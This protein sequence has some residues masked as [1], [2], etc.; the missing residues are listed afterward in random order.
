MLAMDTE[1]PSV[2]RI[3]LDAGADAR[4]KDSDGKTALMLAARHGNLS[5][6]QTLIDAGADLNATDDDGWTALMFVDEAEVAR[7]LLN[8]GADFTIKNKDG[9]TALGMARKYEKT[10]VV[11]LL[12]SRGAPQ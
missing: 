2:V 6:V 5:T 10:E 7:V 9:E 3:L 8:A 1:A 4:A 12:E 11:K